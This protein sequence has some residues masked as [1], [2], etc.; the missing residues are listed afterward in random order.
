MLSKRVNVLSAGY[1]SANSQSL[2][3]PL[4][5][6]RKLLSD[7]GLKL[8]F[9]SD[10]SESIYDCDCLVIDSK[11]FK[12][13]WAGQT[14]FALD[15]IR[16]LSSN[17]SS[18]LWFHTGDSAGSLGSYA[19]AVLPLVK[20]FF[21]SQV[22]SDRSLYQ[23]PLY[24]NRLYTDFYNRRF[25]I[26]D[27]SVPEPDPLL[28]DENL[29]K[30]QVSWNIGF[31]RCFNFYGEY[32]AA[33][34][35]RTQ[36]DPILTIKPRFHAVAAQRPRDIYVRM[37]LNFPRATIGYQRLKLADLMGKQPRVSRAQ[38]YREMKESKVVVSPFGWGEI[39]NRDFE[40]YIYGCLLLKPSMSHLETFPDFFQDGETFISYSW[41]LSDMS[42]KIDDAVANYSRYREIAQEAQARYASNVFSKSGRERFVQH[43]RQLID[44]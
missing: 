36:L 19:A 8:G 14:E 3:N 35:Q 5:I 7:A 1:K 12:P 43:F 22:Y 6:N 39:N 13:L 25:Q 27:D 15:T 21:K 40:A 42:D 9:F 31:A 4:L 33:L 26:E 16:R 38:Y 2:L 29:T 17:I 28:S 41:D 30:I 11:F 10:I 18:I 34:Y 37:G 20:K 44:C 24:G 32:L 23:R